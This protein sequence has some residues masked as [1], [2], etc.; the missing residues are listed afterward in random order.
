MS[1]LIELTGTIPTPEEGRRVE[2]LLKT[3]AFELKRLSLAKGG[4]IPEHHAPGPITVQCLVGRVNFTVEGRPNDLA[5]GT[6]IHLA[7][8]VP[9]ALKAEEDSIVLVTRMAEKR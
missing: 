3:D 2:T 5:A 1:N 7:P 6:L 9:H 4:E 8:R